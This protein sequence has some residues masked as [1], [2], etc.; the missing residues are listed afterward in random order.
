[1]ALSF[2]LSWTPFFLI[3]AP[4]QVLMPNF[5][6]RSHYFVTMVLIYLLAFSH[7]CFN[8]FIT[9]AMSARIRKVA[10]SVPIIYVVYK[11]VHGWC[12]VYLGTY[13]HMFKCI[14]N[15]FDYGFEYGFFNFVNHLSCICHQHKNGFENY[16]R[17]FIFPLQVG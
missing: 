17:K 13:V 16:L 9:F 5:L 15:F 12:F 14:C 2:L 4:T 8:P 3:T 10:L 11:Y 7:S 1:M 6:K